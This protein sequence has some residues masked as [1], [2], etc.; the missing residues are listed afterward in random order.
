MLYDGIDDFRRGAAEF[1]LRAL[2]EGARPLAVVSAE[3]IDALHEDLGRDARRIEFADMEFIG[4]NPARIIP[5]WR[6]FAARRAGTPLRGIGEPVWAERSDAELEEARRHEHLLNLAFEEVNDLWLL[7]P[8]DRSTLDA[9]TLHAAH[10]SHAQEPRDY[11]EIA[12]GGELP[13][14]PDNAS[15]FAL[16]AE[17]L[18]QLRN[19]VN[20]FAFEHNVAASRVPGFVLSIDEVAS[21]SIKYGGGEGTV[22]MWSDDATVCCE[23]RDR[24][25]LTN[26]L[27]GR[28]LPPAA[29]AGGRGVWIANQLCDLVQMRSGA[30][31]TCVRLSIEREHRVSHRAASAASSRRR[32]RTTRQSPH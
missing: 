14:P 21:N 2:T 15:S 28:E 9:E 5:Y 23:V 4:R 12:F 3:K 16:T 26:P 25:E 31:G 29:Y 20:R 30:S 17:L 22:L 32:A 10:Q 13:A 8:Y 24:G 19:V 7:C 1:L 11:L 18:Y 27:V 6:E